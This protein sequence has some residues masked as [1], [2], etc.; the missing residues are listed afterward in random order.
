[1]LPNERTTRSEVVTLPGDVEALVAAPGR[2]L[3]R[4]MVAFLKSQGINIQLACDADSAF[5]EALVHRPNVVLIDDRIPPAGGIELCQRLKGNTRT[6]FVPTVLFAESDLRQHRLRALA[7]GADAIFSPTTDDQERRTRLWALLRTQAIYRRQERR[8]RSQGSAIEDR[9]RWIGGFV[10]DL[11]SSVGAL[12]ANFEYLA[13]GARAKGGGQASAE[14]DECL[15]DIRTVFSQMAHGLRTVA[16]FETF[17]S[18]RMALKENPVILGLL[19]REVCA[20]LAWQAHTAGKTI[21]VS[22]ADDERPVLGDADFL[23]EALTNLASHVLRQPVNHSVEVRT[24]SVGEA[25]RASVSGDGETVGPEDRER[26]FEPYAS[27]GN[28]PPIGQG[29]GLALAK[30]VVELHGGHIW[31]EDAP[32]GGCSFVVELKTV[33]S[34]APLRTVG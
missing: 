25:S 2:N 23:K 28:Q 3:A 14:M 32:S 33:G 8:Q 22:A 16:D 12:Q 1:M 24:W 6:H 10:H 5:E 15:R 9:R 20:E 26:I 21:D 11:Q 27:T 29:L 34:A 4:P 18:G 31:V 17:E 7:A 30:V 19:A 13:Q